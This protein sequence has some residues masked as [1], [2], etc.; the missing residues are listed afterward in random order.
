MICNSTQFTC[1]SARLDLRIFEE[2]CTLLFTLVQ[3]SLKILSWSHPLLTSTVEMST[4]ID[5]PS[6]DLSEFEPKHDSY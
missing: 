3:I 5:M 1:V 4:L 2:Y 6:F